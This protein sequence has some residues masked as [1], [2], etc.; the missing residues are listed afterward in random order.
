MILVA[1]T[2]A[3]GLAYLDA[4]VESVAERKWHT[5]A[6]EFTVTT[7]YFGMAMVKFAIYNPW[8]GVLT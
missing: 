6:R 5:A 3:L 8:S 7:L 1:L 2:L 4:A